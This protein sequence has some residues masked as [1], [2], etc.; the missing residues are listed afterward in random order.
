MPNTSQTAVTKPES[1][2]TLKSY[3]V[4]LLKGNLSLI[5]YLAQYIQFL[6]SIPVFLFQDIFSF[7]GI[8]NHKTLL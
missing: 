5:I 1:K 4:K 8:S 3:R 6:L 7:T 2:L